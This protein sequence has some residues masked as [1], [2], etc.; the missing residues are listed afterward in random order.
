MHANNFSPVK[1]TETNKERHIKR[2]VILGILVLILAGV[3]F[4]IYRTISFTNKVFKS[5]GLGGDITS[6]LPIKTATY[7]SDIDKDMQTGQ[8]INILL[9]GY[10]GAGHDGALLTDSM[11]VVSINPTT[12]EI[13]LISIPRDMWVKIPTSP[14]QNI[15]GKINSAY[16]I[17]LDPTDYP[18]EAA[19]YTGEYGGGDLA[20]AVVGNVL[21]IPIQYY[22]SVDFQAFQTIVND[23]GG[24][25][26]DVTNTFDDYAY[27]SSDSN[28]NGPDCD[29]PMNTPTNCRYY[30]V[31]FTAGEQHMDG[32]V[33][34]EYARSRHALG[35][36][37]SD[38]ARAQR[39]QKL[40]VAI[41][42]KALQI[43]A[44]PQLFNIM[45]SLQDNLQTN[46]T[47]SDIKDLLIIHTW[48]LSNIDHEALTD[49]NFLQA[50]TSSDGQYILTPDAGTN[51]YSQIHQ[52]IADIWQKI[53]LGSEIT[54]VNVEIRS[55]YANTSNTIAL[56]NELKD[57]DIPNTTGAEL[58]VSNPTTTIYD[59][60]N[61]QYPN[62]IN[63]LKAKLHAP[64]SPTPLPAA[65]NPNNSPIVVVI[66]DDF[67]LAQ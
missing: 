66:G 47:L 33:A 55:T 34:L 39:Q 22:V 62:T 59:N 2:Y 24:V 64:V 4:T 58:T 11:M 36:E 49:E 56:S 65:Q 37:G 16:E 44:L 40:M 60:S 42:D 23:L 6:L 18:N 41:K 27:P 61:G 9:L 29:A 7:T 19:P 25:D 20:E 10:G 50:G 31:H 28:T 3:A 17:G 43:N 53:A 13:S 8:N 46:L 35:V 54:T 52:W 67:N 26:I 51:N 5:E 30:H 48:N 38:F 12:K 21:G 32:Q 57:Y 45:S 63:L 15:V 14:T 1:Y